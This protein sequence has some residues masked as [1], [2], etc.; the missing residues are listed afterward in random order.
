[1]NE[2]PLAAAQVPL[3]RLAPALVCNDHL[4]HELGFMPFRLGILALADAV[5]DD[6]FESGARDEKLGT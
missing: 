5:S 4:L 3:G 6:F 1:M 2:E